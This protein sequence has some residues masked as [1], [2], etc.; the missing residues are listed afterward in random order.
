M[1]ES[2][3]GNELYVYN[4]ITL[5]MSYVP[6]KCKQMWTTGEQAQFQTGTYVSF[7]GINGTGMGYSPDTF[8][9]LCHDPSTNAHI[10]SATTY[11]T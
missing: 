9:F 6:K 8:V 1:T 2:K 4:Y 5:H 3:Y 7:G 10:N 11:T